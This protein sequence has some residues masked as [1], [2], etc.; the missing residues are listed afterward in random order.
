[1][2]VAS[3]LVFAAA[4][5]VGGGL[6]AISSTILAREPGFLGPWGSL[7]PLGA[8]SLFFVFGAGVLGQPHV[9]HKFFMVK[10]PLK[11]RW[12]PLLTTFAMVLALLLMFGVGL[13]VKAQVLRGS[14]APLERA[15]DATPL[16]LLRYAPPLLAGI[17]FAGVGAAIMSTVNSFLNVGAAALVR[18]LPR[19][20]R[21]STTN[22]LLAGR[23]ATLAVGVAAAS[24]AQA[25]G[26]LVALLGIF[27]W[28][29]FASTLVPSLA[30]GLN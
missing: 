5:R 7:G 4:L 25:S 20:F 6:G 28:G 13:T 19:V 16:F 17:L 27:G 24:V 21:R 29:L 23:V 2:A 1:M 11:L 10:D 14:L 3:S 15:D 22:E 8:L 9:L 26:S 30:I 12:Y 18:D